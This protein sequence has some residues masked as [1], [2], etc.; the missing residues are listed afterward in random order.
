MFLAGTTV[1]GKIAW[2]TG[3]PLRVHVTGAALR[4]DGYG[5]SLLQE[6]T[7]SECCSQLPALLP[8]SSPSSRALRRSA[9]SSRTC[10]SLLGPTPTPGA[11]RATRSPWT[12]VR[13]L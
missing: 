4:S 6:R 12:W 9:V 8:H 1:L 13:L 10:R 7:P 11:V 3:G 5:E 2:T